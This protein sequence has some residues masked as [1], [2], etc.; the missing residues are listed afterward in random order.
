MTYG[1]FSFPYNS[2]NNNDLNSINSIDRLQDDSLEKQ[3]INNNRVKAANLCDD[4]LDINLTNLVDCKYYSVNEIQQNDNLDNNFNI[5]HNNVNGLETK[6]QNLHNFFANSCLDFDIIT[7]TETSNQD[8]NDEFQSNINL[9]GYNIHSTSTLSSK[10]GTTIFSK[11]KIYS[12]E[13]QDLKVKNEQYESVWIEL[14]NKN[15]KN[16]ICGTI[17]R[18]PHDTTEIF[19]DFLTYLEITLTKLSNENKVIYLCGDFNS[20]LLKYEINHNYRKFYD[21]LSSYGFFP[22]ILLPTRVTK[23]SA[24][25]IDNIFTNDINNSLSSGNIKTDFSDHYSQFISINNQNIDIKLTTFYKR[26]YSKFSEDSFRDDVSIQNFNTAI[27]DVNDQFKDFFFKL[28]GCVERHAPLKKLTPKEIKLKQKPW[29]TTELMKMIKIKNKL[30]NR[31]KRQPDNVNVKLLYNIFRNRV[32]RELKKSKKN[33]Y[34]KYLEDNNNNSKKIWDGIKSIINIKNPKGTSIDQ[35]KANNK[36]IDNPKEIAETVNNFFVNIGPNTE[37]EIPHNP[38]TKPVNYLINR[39]QQNFIITD[40]SN[41]EVLDIINNLENKCSGPQ[42][43]PINLLKLTA[44]LIINPLCNI[45]SNSFNTGIFPDPLKV[46]KVIPIH[47]GSS[48]DEV[49]N[50]RPI[51]LLSIFDKIIEKLV[52]KRLYNFL[53]QHNILYHNQFGFRQNNST[54][55][56]LLQITEK[57]KETIDNRKFGCGIFI[58]L[59]KAFDT[60]NHSILLKK[61]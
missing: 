25:I 15:C 18:H 1:T 46:S 5:F 35:L 41:K 6:F 34:I 47:K 61:T 19:N 23:D 7:I 54:T 59:C 32:N 8:P 56:A 20:D 4:D 44:D 30:F 60:V 27:G 12:I 11:K 36:L 10:G 24:T 57:I 31:K 17:Y 42:S 43:I 21:L 28:D 51:S 3:D 45:I 48:S 52:H 26:D 55:F 22:M 38:V 2:C 14:K 37:K 50:Y 40:I 39:N 9:D 53:E 49:N 16:I 29:I 58:D 33:H 13:R